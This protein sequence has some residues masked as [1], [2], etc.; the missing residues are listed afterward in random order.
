ME[1]EKKMSDKLLKEIGK[2]LQLIREKL[3]F[4]QKDFALEV[5]VS[6]ASLS[7]MEAGNAKP[8][9][10]LIFNLTKK[11]NVNINYLLHGKGPVFLPEGIDSI[12]NI[13]LSDESMAF[14][15]DFIKYFSQSQLIRT[16]MINHFRSYL[17]ENYGLIQK[18]IDMPVLDALNKEIKENK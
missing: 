7:E 10:E 5:E 16:S 9:F 12:K 3:N 2:R 13:E 11:F 4:L 18:D 14:L 8:R 15:E 17:I 1:N 6:N